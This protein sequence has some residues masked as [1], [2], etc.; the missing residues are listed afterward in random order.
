MR[1]CD[2]IL[3]GSRENFPSTIW[4][5]VLAAAKSRN[6]GAR[7]RAGR[8]LRAYWRPVYAYVRA[9]WR[10]PVED[11]K[12]LTQSF[13][14]HFLEKRTLARMRPEQG[15]FRGYLKRALR[16][17]LID[18]ERHA[19][20]RRPSTPVLSLDLPAAELERIGPAAADELPEAAYDREWFRT[21]FD[22]AIAELQATLENDGKAT[23]FAAFRAYCLEPSPGAT[24]RE[25]AERLGLR[26]ND[27]RNYLHHCR[28]TL[29]TLLRAR[30]RD[31]V[32]TD[33]EVESEIERV[34][35]S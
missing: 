23:Y 31:T 22:A 29:R 4:S 16:H 1:Q 18:A 10:K 11:C 20:A 21:L 9:S 13:F 3:G 35:A 28:Q 26:E 5:D 25:I 2:T 15:S 33:G 12:D 27:V 24:Y 14:A 32:G 17:F 6:D 34:L 30:V 19:A 8:L 7:E